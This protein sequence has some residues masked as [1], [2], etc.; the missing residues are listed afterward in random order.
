MSLSTELT[1]LLHK[2][3]TESDNRREHDM[4]VL[5]AAKF[6]TQRVELNRIYRAEV[7]GDTAML[8]H[9]AAYGCDDYI[10]SKAAEFLTNV[11]NGVVH[12]QIRGVIRNSGTGAP[13]SEAANA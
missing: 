2:I 5:A 1:T 9:Y 7:A 4:C 11:R 3:C 13:T 12:T 8:E 6:L 10:K